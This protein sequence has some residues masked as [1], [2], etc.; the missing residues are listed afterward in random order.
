M[1]C[2][3]CVK[4]RAPQDVVNIW[5]RHQKSQDGN[6][7]FGNIG[8]RGR[9][10]PLEAWSR[11]KLTIRE[12]YQYGEDLDH[13]SCWDTFVDRICLRHRGTGMSTD[14]DT[15]MYSLLEYLHSHSLSETRIRYLY[16]QGLKTSALPYSR[17]P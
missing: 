1:L 4:S 6:K 16:E 10:R 12:A 17:I 7:E 8:R 14:A 13:D 15:L 3:I 11:A 2:N 5:D 9:R